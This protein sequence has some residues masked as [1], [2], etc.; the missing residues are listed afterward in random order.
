VTQAACGRF[1]C[2]QHPVYSNT[3]RL[4]PSQALW[5]SW[6]LCDPSAALAA[7]HLPDDAQSPCSRDIKPRV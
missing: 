5:P 6:A 3:G 2:V 4:I 7:L 1:V